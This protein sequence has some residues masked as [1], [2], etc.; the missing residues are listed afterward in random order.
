MV[1]FNQYSLRRGAILYAGPGQIQR[2]ASQ[3]E[4]TGYLVL[5]QPE[6]CGVSAPHFLWPTSQ[7][8][9]T[10]DFDTL[11]SLVRIMFELKT[12]ELSTPPDRI[13]WR[14]LSAVLELWEGAVT[15]QRVREGNPPSEAFEA[16]SH[17]L[18]TRFAEHRELAWY[19]NQLG[20][21][22]KTLTRWCRQATGTNAK[23]Y[24]DQRVV[25]EAKRLLVHTDHAVE[26]IAT[27]LGFSESTN[28]VKFF[29]RLEQTT[30]QNFRHSY[31]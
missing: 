29:K 9:K 24:I 10:G 3:S 12:R 4:L 22:E 2:Y 5:F 15:R 21:S 17:L 31:T 30:P 11:E 13:T 19:A 16:L 1:D 8:P 6:V 27:R 28:F 20:Y 7:R 25:L 23:T 26:T 18:E 14:M